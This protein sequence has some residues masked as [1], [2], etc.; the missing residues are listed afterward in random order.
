MHCKTYVFKTKQFSAIPSTKQLA[1]VISAKQLSTIVVGAK[2]L[3]TVF[4]YS[5]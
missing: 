5:E 1:T 2:Y 3:S 4:F